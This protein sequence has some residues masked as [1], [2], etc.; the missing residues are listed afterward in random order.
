MIIQKDLKEFLEAIV[1]IANVFGLL[2]KFLD[3]FFDYKFN[4]RISELEA[5]KTNKN[6]CSSHKG[7]QR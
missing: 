3:R 5:K 2:L 4:Q 6:R 7:K 1:L